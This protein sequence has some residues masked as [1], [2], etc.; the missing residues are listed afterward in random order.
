M[1][2]DPGFQNPTP[3][4]A[5]AVARKLYTSWFISYSCREM[6]SIS[7]TFCSST[8]QELIQTHFLPSHAC[9][10]LLHSFAAARG[11]CTSL[12]KTKRD[13][14]CLP[15][16]SNRPFNFIQLAALLKHLF[17]FPIPTSTREIAQL[18]ENPD[19]K[20]LKNALLISCVLRVF[21]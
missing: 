16:S 1:I 18:K 7:N 20:T 14:D 13:L 11:R 15:V 2:P 21:F 5:P 6:H 8:S 17:Q 3:Y 12:S 9:L 19:N 4:L 10:Y